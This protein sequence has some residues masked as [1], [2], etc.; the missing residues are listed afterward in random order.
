MLSLRLLIAA[1]ITF[2][3][4][5]KADIVGYK[6]LYRARTNTKVEFLYDYHRPSE[7]M[8]YDQANQLSFEHLKEVLIQGS[9]SY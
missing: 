5:I 8:T 4:C 2:S 3:T 6:R 7:K 9:K 1:L